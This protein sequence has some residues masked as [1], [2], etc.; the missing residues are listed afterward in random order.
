RLEASKRRERCEAGE[1]LAEL[2]VAMSILAVAVV[3]IVGAMANAVSLSTRH[4]NQASANTYLLSASEVLK[5]VGYR[6]CAAGATP[7]AQYLSDI[8]G[9]PNWIALPSGWSLDVPAVSAVSP[10]GSSA[11]CPASDTG[12]EAVSLQ[13]TAPD[14]FKTDG[15]FHVVKRSN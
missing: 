15:N 9:S 12:V 14:G 3:V 6:P 5:S 2:L 11:T 10:D 1:T 13:V 4:R 7:K 8:T